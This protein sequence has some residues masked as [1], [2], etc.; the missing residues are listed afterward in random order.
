MY[1]Y[2]VHVFVSVFNFLRWNKIIKYKKK[3]I[4]RR[5]WP[6]QLKFSGFVVF[7]ELCR[8]CIHYFLSKLCIET[9]LDFL[10]HVS[11]FSQIS[12][13]I[14]VSYLSSFENCQNCLIAGVIFSQVSPGI[15]LSRWQIYSAGVKLQYSSRAQKWFSIILWSYIYI[16]FAMIW[17]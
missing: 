5:I 11:N 7:S 9:M 14:T 17:N 4:L 13:L 10:F 8:I 1:V 2:C 6:I 12:M 15:E 3:D 16:Y